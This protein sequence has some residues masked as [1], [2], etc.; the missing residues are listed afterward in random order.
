MTSITKTFDARG[1]GCP[2][3]MIELNKNINGLN[4][5]DV[6]EF[7]SGEDYVQQDIVSW[8]R[9]T[10]HALLDRI[11]KGAVS[12]YIIRKGE[13]IRRLRPV[14]RPSQKTGPGHRQAGASR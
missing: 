9:R 6:L 4:K 12:H 3:V 7:I 8:S 14:S 2:M 11:D 1:L 5:G 13:R 10:G